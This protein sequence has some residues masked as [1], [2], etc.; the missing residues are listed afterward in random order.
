MDGDVI[1]TILSEVADREGV[2]AAELDPPLYEAV[3]PDALRTLFRDASG[4]VSF[5]YHGFLVTVTD[6]G[7]VAV[8]P[9]EAP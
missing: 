5:E 1:E 9:M 7:T 6:D 3:E 2:P 8:E 4:S